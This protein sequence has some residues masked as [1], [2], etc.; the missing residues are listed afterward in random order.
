MEHK[1][2]HTHSVVHPVP[3]NN[4]K[5]TKR[6][7]V[8]IPPI[9]MLISFITILA[10]LFS[11]CKALCVCILLY[12]L[13]KM[14]ENTITNKRYKNTI[15]VWL[16]TIARRNVTCFFCVQ[17]IGAILSYSDTSNHS[18]GVDVVN[19]WLN[20]THDEG[21]TDGSSG[22]TECEWDPIDIFT[23]LR[24]IQTQTRRIF[25]YWK[26]AG[27][28]RTNRLNCIVH[29]Q[30]RELTPHIQKHTHTHSYGYIDTIIACTAIT[31]TAA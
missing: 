24:S 16:H 7:I 10:A 2:T 9:C 28:K 27:S 14:F 29:I 25:S 26:K 13:L 4:T 15:S 3:F 12:N 21:W 17:Y 22:L 30:L 20:N 19:C 8:H 1:K 18:G 5:F 6:Y 11:I 23:S 31:H